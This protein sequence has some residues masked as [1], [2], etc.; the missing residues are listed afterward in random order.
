[1]TANPQASRIAREVGRGYH[2]ARQALNV[3]VNH[4]WAPYDAEAFLRA[5][6]EREPTTGE[7]ANLIDAA[8]LAVS[9]LE[10]PEGGDAF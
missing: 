10:E 1:M 8:Q 5:A 4:G 7:F 6:A 2:E 3:L 9:S